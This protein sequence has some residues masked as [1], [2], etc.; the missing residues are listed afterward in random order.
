VTAGGLRIKSHERG[1]RVNLMVNGRPVAAHAGET[2]FAVL[3]AEGIRSLSQPGGGPSARAR[4]G[5]CGMGVC[6]E[7]R[8]TIDGVPD[9]RA[10]M[11]EVR[12]GMEVLTDGR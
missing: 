11:T 12:E 5:F 1:R 2:L 3:L 8:V 10:C 4:G 9:R 7:C 6:Q